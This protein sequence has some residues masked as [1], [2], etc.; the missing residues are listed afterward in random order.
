[1]MEKKLSDLSILWRLI[2]QSRAFWPHL[3]FIFLIELLAAPLALL[4]PIP[5]K[6]AVDSA[7]GSQGLPVFIEALLQRTGLNPTTSI[8]VLA[9][10]LVIIIAL[11]NQLQSFGKWLLQTY[12]GE[13][14]LLDFRAELLRTAQRLSLSYHDMKGTTDSIYRIQYDA[15][16]IQWILIN[17]ITPFIVAGLTLMGM[18]YITVRI[19]R[20]LALIALT[21]IPVLLLLV[22]SYRKRLR[23]QWKEV[24]KIESSALSVVQEVL[25]SLRIVKAFTQEEREEQR[26]IHCSQE[27]IWARLRVVLSESSFGLFVGLTMAAGTSAVLFVGAQH[28][29]SGI[30]TLGELLIVMTYLTQLYQ[31]LKTIGRQVATL[32]GAMASA[33]RTFGLLDKS[34]DVTEQPDALPLE[35]AAGEI[36]FSNVSFAYGTDHILRDISFHISAGACVG[37]AGKTGAGKTT[38]ISLLTRFYDPAGG[39]ILLDNVDIRKYKL[40]DLRNQF[41]LVLQEPVLLS[42]SIAENISY[43]MPGAGREDIMRAAQLANAST[44][45]ERQRDRYDTLVGERGMRLS[46]G[47]RQR[48]ALARAFLKDA[49]VLLLDEPTSA[50]DINTEAAILEAMERLMKGRTTFMIAHRLSTL[51]NCDV[52]LMI[53][54]GS[55]V[56]VTSDV[57]NAIGSLYKLDENDLCTIDESS[58]TG[59]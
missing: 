20:T 43:G 23:K 37:V 49:P 33:E 24:K 25:S 58:L 21:V 55:L 1:M 56:T 11:L 46:G 39:S 52:L 40:K 50:V 19:D 34:P 29:R 16:A 41:A 59:D 48:I 36:T 7:I 10:G 35:R 6:I 31:P 53:N 42:T 47:E 27:G 57:S 12:T 38:L 9:A 17:G 4:I 15:P 51:K 30:L 45:I 13:K 2:Q 28:V 32:Q 8:L 5:L 54:D 22:Y 44:F 18:I 26:F 3:I 14:L